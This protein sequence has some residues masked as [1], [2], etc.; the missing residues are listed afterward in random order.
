MDLKATWDCQNS[1]LSSNCDLNILEYLF[2]YCPSTAA[3][4]GQLWEI[5]LT[6][7]QFNDWGMWIFFK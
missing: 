6:K 5:E 7:D 4:A 3:S 1:Y 2:S